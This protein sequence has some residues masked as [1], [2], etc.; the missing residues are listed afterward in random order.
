MN[1]KI[2]ELHPNT[3]HLFADLAEL[4]L[5]A[6]YD[7]RTKLHKND[8]E[9]ILNRGPISHEEIDHEEVEGDAEPTGAERNSRTDRQLDDVMLHLNYR[10]SA[11]A[12]F[13]PF[14]VEGEELILIDK[15]NHQ[16]RIYRLL[17][18]C[19]RLR[20]FESKGLAQRWAK[21]FTNVS[22]IAMAGLFPQHAALRIFDANSD[23]RKNY[24]STDLRIALKKLGQ[25]LRVIGI[26]HIEC[27]KVHPSGDAGLD[28]VAVLD[29]DDG[30]TTAFALLG[31]C[32]AQETGWPKKTLEAHPMKYR[33]YY[34]MQFDYPGVMFTPVCFRTSDGEWSNNQSA[35][36]IF[37]AD[38]VRILKLL[39]LQKKWEDI[40]IEKWFLDFEVELK[41]VKFD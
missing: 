1:F 27:E 23:D 14:R 9:A 28:L 3:P 11:M 12:P 6:G 4:L 29:F 18:A 32:G 35:N 7:G 5:I 22:K 30:A 41:T 34:Q 17:L 31:Q 16:N 10:S 20:S 24:Y 15:L 36:G 26:N 38:R 39:D 13:Y 25:D 8:L 2:G 33:N 40:T 19:S 37:L 21:A